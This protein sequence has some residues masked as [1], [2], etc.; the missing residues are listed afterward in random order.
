MSTTSINRNRFILNGGSHNLPYDMTGN[1]VTDGTS[2]A[3]ITTE[4]GVTIST[5]GSYLS[6]NEIYQ[7]GV[8]MGSGTYQVISSTGTITDT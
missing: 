4:A 1:M 3:Q 7:A 2:F 6:C 8:G 5:G